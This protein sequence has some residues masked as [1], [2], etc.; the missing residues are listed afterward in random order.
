M[1]YFLCVGL[2]GVRDFACYESNDADACVPMNKK[3]DGV[4]DCTEGEDERDC[5]G[6]NRFGCYVEDDSY[7]PLGGGP[8][9][10]YHCP[11][12]SSRCDMMADCLNST[13]DEPPDCKCVSS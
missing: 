7:N 5:C 4:W 11:F 8:V 6:E 9:I 10:R 12:N 2:C 3:C 1:T 13:I